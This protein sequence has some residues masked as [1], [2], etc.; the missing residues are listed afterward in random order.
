MVRRQGHK[1]VIV[2]VEHHVAP[3]INKLDKVPFPRFGPFVGAYTWNDR[4]TDREGGLG[5]AKG[6]VV[7]ELAPWRGK[8]E[9]AP[10]AWN[11]REV[12]G[13]RVS[14]RSGSEERACVEELAA[15][16]TELDHFL[17]VEADPEELRG[18]GTGI[19]ISNGDVRIARSPG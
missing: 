1:V 4:V 17:L 19:S 6:E 7:M 18:R 15:G 2:W 16:R 13:G 5:E 3:E 11:L 10:A 9:C 12:R 8:V 14:E